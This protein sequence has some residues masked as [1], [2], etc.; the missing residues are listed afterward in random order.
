[1]ITD[2]MVHEA[3][4]IASGAHPVGAGDGDTYVVLPPT[5]HSIR[6][7][8]EAIAPMI[9]AAALDAAAEVVRKRMQLSGAHQIW[10]A[11]FGDTV[12][13]DDRLV[14]AIEP[15]ML[16]YMSEVSVG[17]QDAIRALKEQKP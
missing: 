6:A 16:K 7:A 12:G 9:R 3:W 11:T 14:Q 5:K 17:L 10:C 13:H 8:I 2:E 4:R 15:F 1:M